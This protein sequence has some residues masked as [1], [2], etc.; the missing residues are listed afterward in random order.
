MKHWAT[1]IC[2]AVISLLGW[3]YACAETMALPVP[4][5]TIFPGQPIQDADFTQK[6]FEVSDIAKLNFVVSIDQ[7]Q[8]K[9]A[10]K[11][12][13]VGKAIPLAALV[14]SNDV[15]KG[16]ETIAHF[17][18]DGIDIQGVLSPLRDG[19]AGQIVPCRNPSSGLTVDALVMADGSL[20]VSEK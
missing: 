5:R 1:G 3:R 4:T 9:E 12:L 18:A 15:R 13:P 6:D 7:M 19:V 17:I 11:I 10:A 2:V 16:K 20:S 14:K 8:D